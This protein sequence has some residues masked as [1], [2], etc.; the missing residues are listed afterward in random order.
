MTSIPQYGS[1]CDYRPDFCKAHVRLYSLNFI[2]LHHVQQHA[3]PEEVLVCPVVPLLLPPHGGLDQLD[4]EAQ[5]LAPVGLQLEDPD[6][7]DDAEEENIR[8]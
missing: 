6:G 1:Q 7:W 8:G 5:H 3:G 4:V 2:H